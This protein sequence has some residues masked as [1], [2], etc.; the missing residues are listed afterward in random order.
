M[1]CDD[2]SKYP[3]L[4]ATG[5]CSNCSNR[6]HSV[7]YDLC[8]TCS[9]T[10][11]LCQVC[12]DPMTVTPTPPKKGVFFVKK[13]EKDN[14]GTVTLKI[15]EEVHITLPED[16]YAYKEW[17][18]DTYSYSYLDLEDR[19][20]FTPDPGD[21]QYGSRTIVF[22]ATR[23]GQGKIDLKLANTYGGGSSTTWTITVKVK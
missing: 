3:A 16:R 19:G 18:V 7:S 20:T 8:E 22:R 5:R 4:T 12:L 23:S 1:I 17:Q 2:C 11:G 21:H 15:G 6:T 10:L 13:N 14:G 9:K